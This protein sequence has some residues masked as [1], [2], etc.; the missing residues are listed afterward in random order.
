VDRRLGGMLFCEDGELIRGWCKR[1]RYVESTAE[2]V[3]KG[4]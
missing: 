2:E 4:A 3:G 1:D